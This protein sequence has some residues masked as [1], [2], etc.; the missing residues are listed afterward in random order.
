MQFAAVAAAA[1]AAESFAETRQ[2]VACGMHEDHLGFGL[3]SNQ[4]WHY[5]LQCQRFGRAD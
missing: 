3:D 1:A 2:F 4:F 5:S